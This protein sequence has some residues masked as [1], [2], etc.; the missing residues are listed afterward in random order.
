MS[1][2]PKVDKPK[3]NQ[4]KPYEW[5]DS[6]WEKLMTKQKEL[7]NEIANLTGKIKNDMDYIR[8]LEGS[9]EDLKKERLELHMENGELKDMVLDLGGDYKNWGD[10]PFQGNKK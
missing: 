1:S 2:V 5:V 8:M 4:N 9:I 6:Q 3:Y 10:E 7:E